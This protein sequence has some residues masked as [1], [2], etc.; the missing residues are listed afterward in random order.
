MSAVHLQA[1]LS[2]LAYRPGSLDGEIGPRT[3]AALEEAGRDIRK[4]RRLDWRE[5]LPVLIAEVAKERRDTPILTLSQIRSAYPRFATG[6]D[7]PLGWVDGLNAALWYIAADPHRARFFI[8]QLAH[9]SAGFATLTEYASGT[10]YEGRRDL[11]NTDRGDGVRYKGRGPIQITGRANYR[12]VGRMLGVPAEEHPE[13]LATPL[14][15]FLAAGLYWLDNN[16][17][18]EADLGNITAITKAI[19]GGT[20]G[21]SSRVKLTAAAEGLFERRA[22]GATT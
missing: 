22:A 15:G 6:R 3:L 5:A 10:A 7:N 18:S 1:T 12:R 13:I 20:N 17:N 4:I 11:G 9:E 14:V 2:R 16:L 8:G 21:L 19:N